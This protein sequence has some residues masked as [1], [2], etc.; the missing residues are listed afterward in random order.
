MPPCEVD[1]LTGEGPEG[2]G[3]VLETFAMAV[4]D[5]IRGPGLYQ[6]VFAEGLEEERQRLEQME[7]LLLQGQATRDPEKL[8]TIRAELKRLR[9]ARK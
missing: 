8:A 2:L 5:P 9:E 1:R 3:D 6:W 7:A 4:S